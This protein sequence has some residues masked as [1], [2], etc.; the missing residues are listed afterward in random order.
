MSFT[1]SY[2]QLD[3][4][5]SL[6]PVDDLDQQMKLLAEQPGHQV[7]RYPDKYV[8]STRFHGGPTWL[9]HFFK[10]RGW[11]QP[12]NN[13]L[14][15]SR[16]IVRVLF[17]YAG[18]IAYNPNENNVPPPALPGETEEQLKKRQDARWLLT[19][20]VFGKHAKV[21]MGGVIQLVCE[22]DVGDMMKAEKDMAGDWGLIS[23]GRF[24]VFRYSHDWTEDTLFAEA[25]KFADQILNGRPAKGPGLKV[26][27]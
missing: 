10:Q 11:T 12:E 15:V 26:C 7:A 17:F 24:F 4:I 2:P 16:I 18:L 25:H 21:T 6:D 1:T 9:P 5:L 13:T 3:E 23:A 14:L 19:W 27:G 20:R 22:D 8:L